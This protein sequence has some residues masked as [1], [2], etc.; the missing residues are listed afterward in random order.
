MSSS[1]VASL[2]ALRANIAKMEDKVVA[3]SVH[4]DRARASLS[5]VDADL[6]STRTATASMVAEEKRLRVQTR[7]LKQEAL[8]HKTA[9]EA[10]AAENGR[11]RSHLVERES[12]LKACT[13]RRDGLGAKYEKAL[14]ECTNLPVDD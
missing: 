7:H 8:A 9:M 5:A 13:H 12:A 3:R 2:M 14:A 10:R 1:D 11:A 4:M 6:S